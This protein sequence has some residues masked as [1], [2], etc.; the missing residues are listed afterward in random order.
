MHTD[1]LNGLMLRHLPLALLIVVAAAS[2]AACEPQG[3]QQ[4]VQAEQRAPVDTA[5]VI[6]T[7]DSLRALYEQTVATGDFETMGTLLADEAVM[8]GPGGPQ[9]DSLRTASEYPW[10]PGATLDITPI[11][12]I[13][14]SE[15]WAYDF[16][17]STATYT[18]EGTGEARTLRDTYLLLLRNT[19]DGWKLYREVASPDLPPD[20]TAEQ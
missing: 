3:Q 20:T 17:T 8:V 1:P 13:V 15:E 19:S 12:T 5:A 2:L 14:M 18:P 10:P 9:W 7:I 4:A 11:E 6:A 16:G